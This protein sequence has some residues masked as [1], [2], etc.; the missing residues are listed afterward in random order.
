[1][2]PCA[3]FYHSDKAR[4]SIHWVVLFPLTQCGGTTARVVIGL[5]TVEY[6]GAENPIL[7]CG[8][9]LEVLYSVNTCDK[10]INSVCAI[11]REDS[12]ITESL[13]IE[14]ATRIS[15]DNLQLKKY[16][17]VKNPLYFPWKETTNKY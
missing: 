10:C 8:H 15:P 3:T 16:F 5:E 11:Y 2:L 1:M 17:R 12:R 13:L 4:P 7:T 9:F 6:E 14:F